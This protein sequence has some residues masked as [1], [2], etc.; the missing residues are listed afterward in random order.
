MQIP[1]RDGLKVIDK[2]FIPTVN[3]VNNQITYN[4]LPDS[5]KEKVVFVVQSWERREYNYN[6]EYVVL[7]DTKEYHYNNYYCLPKTRRFIYELGKN[8]KYCIFDD[9]L[10]FGRRN[11]KYSSNDSNMEKSKRKCTEDDMIEMFDVFDEWLNIDTVTVC[12]CSQVEN[13][14]LN[15]K[16]VENSSITSAFWID[17]KK[18]KDILISLDLT[19]VRVGEDVCFLLSLLKN[20]LRNRVSGEFCQFNNSNLKKMKSTVWD[21]QT[22][23]QTLNDHKHLEKMFPNVFKILYDEYGKRLDGGYKN[24]GKSR[25]NWKKA[26]NDPSINTLKNFYND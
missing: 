13:P 18:F 10:N 14:P 1:S 3:R 19:S 22:F 26:F 5:L 21:Q 25:I 6:C 15:K 8:M 24:F 12:G 4:A 20:G 16:F 2:I 11:S 23:E 9:D 7:P 17:G